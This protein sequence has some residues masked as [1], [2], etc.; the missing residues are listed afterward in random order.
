MANF[1]RVLA[2]LEAVIIVVRAKARAA[3]KVPGGIKDVL[4]GLSAYT[5]RHYRRLEDLMD[6]SHLVE[7]TLRQMDDVLGGAEAWENVDK[8]QGE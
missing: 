5:E 6:E 1:W 8:T 2:T 7:Y 3:A 4:E